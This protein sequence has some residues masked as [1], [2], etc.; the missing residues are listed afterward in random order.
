MCEAPAHL[1]LNDNDTTGAT[2]MLLDPAVN[3]VERLTLR[4]LEPCH[5]GKVRDESSAPP[6]GQKKKHLKCP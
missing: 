4:S 2:N 1:R 3:V 5:V 6:L